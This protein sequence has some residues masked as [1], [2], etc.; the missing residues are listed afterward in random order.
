MTKAN[1]T[2][3]AEGYKRHKDESYISMGRPGL[4]ITTKRQHDSWERVK[5]ASNL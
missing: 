5:T 3:A 4:V 1:R 2:A